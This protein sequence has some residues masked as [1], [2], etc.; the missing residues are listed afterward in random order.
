MLGSSRSGGDDLEDDNY[1]EPEDVENLYADATSD[2]VDDKMPIGGGMEG[3]AQ[4]QQGQKTQ[5]KKKAKIVV[6]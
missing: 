5:G 6:F 3:P 2:G 4:Q 1:Y